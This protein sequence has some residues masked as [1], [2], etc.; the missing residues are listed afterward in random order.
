MPLPK[1]IRDE[2]VA[3]WAVELVGRLA[4]IGL[5]VPETG[6]WL[7]WEMSAPAQLVSGVSAL[8]LGDCCSE[9]IRPDFRSVS[10][11]TLWH[12]RIGGRKSLVDYIRRLHVRQL[13]GRGASSE[14]L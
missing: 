5:A 9:V 1:G 10:D 8:P 6:S 4:I 7:G 11:S 14:E 3:F 12:L 13:V 2:G